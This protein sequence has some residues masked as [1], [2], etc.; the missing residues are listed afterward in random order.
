VSPCRGQCLLWVKSGHSRRKKSCPLY[1]PK[2]D[3]H[4][5]ERPVGSAE[6]LR[7]A[8]FIRTAK[9]KAAKA[10][11]RLETLVSTEWSRQ[12]SISFMRGQS[13]HRHLQVM[14][15]LFHTDPAQFTN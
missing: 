4:Q 1:P 6:K 3:I 5:R 9:G 12:N 10:G 11:G 15:F 13:A 7:A 2:A 8:A 14:C